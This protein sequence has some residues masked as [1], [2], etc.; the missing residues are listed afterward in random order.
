MLDDRGI[1]IFS[2]R[3]TN[4]GLD[5]VR[6][7][8]HL[9][10]EKDPKFPEGVGKILDMYK[11]IGYIPLQIDLNKESFSL[12]HSPAGCYAIYALAAKKMGEETLSRKLFEEAR[13]KLNM[14]KNNYYSFSLYLLATTEN[15]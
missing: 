10:W 4:Y 3:G 14:E 6:T 9:A 1:S 15:I 8:L 2:E 12:K 5:A 7:L 13:E 11:K